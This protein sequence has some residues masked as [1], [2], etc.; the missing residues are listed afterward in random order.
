[1]SGGSPDWLD[2]AAVAAVYGVSARAVRLAFR[3]A[4]TGQRW[5]GAELVLRRVPSA[6]RGGL[7][8]QVRADSLPPLENAPQTA[9]LPTPVP[10]YGRAKTPLKRS[11]TADERFAIIAPVLRLPRGTPERRQALEAAAA[12]SGVPRRTL[13]R[14]IAKYEAEGGRGIKPNWKPRRGRRKA[15]VTYAWDAFA[16][17]HLDAAAAAGVAA[18]IEHYCKRLWVSSAELSPRQAARF[19]SHKLRELTIEAGYAG[20]AGALRDACKLSRRFVTRH[21]QRYQWAAVAAQDAKKFADNQPRVRRTF[22]GREPMEIVFGDVHPMDVLLPRAD[23]STFTAKL[24]A[25]LDAATQRVFLYPVFLAKGEGVRQEH[26]A[27]ALIAMVQAPGWGAPKTLYIDNGGEYNIM[28]MASD[29][30]RLT[31]EVRS[32]DDGPAVGDGAAP[33]RRALPYNAAAKPIEGTFRILERDYFSKLDGWIGGDRMA[34]KTQNV[35]R[36]PVPYLHGE[37]AFRRD[38]ANCVTLY[39]TTPQHGDIRGLSPREAFNRA[40]NE[41]GWKRVDINPHALLAAFARDETRFVREGKFQ[42]AGRHFTAPEIQALPAGKQLHLRVPIS[43]PFNGIPVLDDAGRLL[44]MAELDRPYDALDRA[45]AEESA[46]RK[47]RARVAVRAARADAPALDMRA[48]MAKLAAAAEPEAVPES[49]GRIEWDENMAAT[50]RELA[51]TPKERRAEK[52]ERE[53]ISRERQRKAADRFL[54][55]YKKTGTDG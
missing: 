14:W 3:A 7:A 1:M 43:G 47:K 25:F 49:A 20:D 40:V 10:P 50:G 16:A 2:A 22:A 26:V 4:E 18:D 33:I 45:G 52:D 28:D 42:Y 23:G 36:E 19:A 11:A 51:K 9:N 54:E 8:W 34:K 48:E 17:A 46:R 13:Y 37:A 55:K 24:I 21:R 6:G 30:F 39:E 27:A 53:R 35:G 29:A 15:A 32:L 12:N 44:C 41:R 5:R 31:T 38:L